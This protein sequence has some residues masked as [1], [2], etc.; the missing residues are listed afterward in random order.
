MNK[1]SKAFSRG[2]VVKLV[3]LPKKRMWISKHSK[4]GMTGVVVGNGPGVYDYNVYW[5]EKEYKGQFIDKH[6]INRWQS[7]FVKRDQIERIREK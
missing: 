6:K 2:D 7:F 4:L 3:K 5:S 1:K